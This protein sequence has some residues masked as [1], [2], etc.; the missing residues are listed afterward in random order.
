MSTIHG[1]KGGEYDTVISFGLLQ[2][3]VPNFNDSS[4]ESAKKT[5]ICHWFEGQKNLHLIS[6][7]G[8][9]SKYKDYESTKVLSGTKFTYDADPF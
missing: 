5:V 6:E 1:V 9:R 2:D 8:R 4:D 7:R 3:M